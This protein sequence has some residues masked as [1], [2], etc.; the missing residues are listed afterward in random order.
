MLTK[1]QGEKN[2]RTKAIKQR[3]IGMRQTKVP[4][5][6]EEKQETGA[7]GDTEAVDEAAEEEEVPPTV[8]SE[9]TPAGTAARPATMHVTVGAQDRLTKRKVKTAKARH[10]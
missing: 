4:T 8:S 5:I 1:S 6:R 3:L 10:D 2:N 7:A 9:I